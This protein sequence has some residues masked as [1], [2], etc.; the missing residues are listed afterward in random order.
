MS[1]LYIV[2]LCWIQDTS[3]FATL[4]LTIGLFSVVGLT[5]FICSK[6]RKKGN[7]KFISYAEPTIRNQSVIMDVMTDSLDKLRMSESAPLHLMLYT[8]PTP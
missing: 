6:V 2:F 4:T 5:Y 7:I 3:F 1:A 8:Q